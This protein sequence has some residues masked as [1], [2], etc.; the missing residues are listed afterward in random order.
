MIALDV[1]GSFCQSA[2]NGDPLSRA[3]YER[4]RSKG[5]QDTRAVIAVARR[6]VTVLWPMLRSR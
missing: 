1:V 3:F 4:K 6:R 2:P 5:K